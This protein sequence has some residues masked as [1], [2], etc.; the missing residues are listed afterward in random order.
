MKNANIPA[1]ILLLA[2][3]HPVMADSVFATEIVKVYTQSHD[4]SAAHMIMISATL[5]SI[6]NNNRLYILFEDKELLASALANYIA[7]KPV[8][9]LYTTTASP[10]T[11]SGHVGGFTCKL[12]SI[13]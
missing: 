13:F 11:I 9:I 6:C 7:G 8:D 4:G 2:L 5:P 10:V 3:S 1:A 12:I